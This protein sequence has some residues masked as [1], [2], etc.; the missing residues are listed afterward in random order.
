[1]KLANLKMNL[2]MNLNR[3]GIRP[4]KIF[5]KAPP[6]LIAPFIR[7]YYGNVWT[8]LP[9]K[10]KLLFI[11]I[12]KT[13][14]ISI[15]SAIYGSEIG[16]TPAVFYYALNKTL[17]LR[18]TT[19]TVIRNPFD[20][21]CSIFY[22][23]SRSEKLGHWVLGEPFFSL[24]PSP[25]ELALSIKRDKKKYI[26]FMAHGAAFP[27]VEWLKVNGKIAIRNLFIFERMDLLES[28]LRRVLNN[29]DFVLPHYNSS[30]RGIS[31]EQD[32]NDSAKEVV[33]QLYQEDWRL[34]Q[35]LRKKFN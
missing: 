12:P 18:T 11:H 6:C 8:R 9:N 2:K 20:R 29:E 13:G 32:L 15:S 27:Q 30:G 25:T 23:H 1:M 19:F 22:S 7:G 4:Y 3:I 35:S 17:F 14:G 26:L 5:G 10:P 24:Y 34:W 33:A 21:F 31:W 16:H 28:Y